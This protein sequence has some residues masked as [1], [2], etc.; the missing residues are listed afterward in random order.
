MYPRWAE[1][2]NFGF[3]EP[4]FIF[5][6]PLSWMLGA[7]LSLIV[8]W[9]I[10]PAV[11]T[12][13]SQTISGISSYALLRRFLPSQGALVGAFIY[14]VNPYALL[15]IYE[16]GAYG[17]VLACALLPFLL[18]ACLDLCGLAECRHRS[19]PQTIVLFALAFS[20]VWLSNVP[21]G[22][23]T[24]YSVGLV[25]AWAAARR[26]SIQPLW[27]GA[28]GLILGFGLNA[29]HLLPV[30]YEQHWASVQQL[31]P[32]WTHSNNFLAQ[33]FLYAQIPSPRG[34]PFA[35]I[36]SNVAVL[37]VGIT[38][39]AS[40]IAHPRTY[41]PQSNSPAENVWVV[42]LLLLILAI[43]LMMPASAIFWRHLPK[44]AV[45][46]FPWRWMGILAVP[47]AFSLAAAI[48]PRRGR[49]VW[50]AMVVAISATVG[51]L[52]ARRGSWGGDGTVTLQK[53]I[54]SGHGFIGAAE[55]YPAGEGS[56]Y[57]TYTYVDKAAPTVQILSVRG[58]EKAASQT[59]IEVMKWTAEEKE[60]RI[61]ASE[62]VSVALRLLNY[63]SWQ[64]KVNGNV[65]KRQQPKGVDKIIVLAP[66][67]E[68]EISARFMR[69]PDR[70]CGN[71]LSLA[72]IFVSVILLWKAR[73]A[74]WHRR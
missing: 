58:L 28:C 19:L 42:L 22:V 16:R 61:R 11:F 10:V 48:A 30:V 57:S 37:L 15:N 35:W 3:G 17:E 14:A 72:S 64:V 31:L 46:Q 51:N 66:A 38:L 68:S 36:A 1:W 29:F 49:W 9:K 24:S 5:Y 41:G 8:P 32:A 20:A 60:V 43:F 2:A 12:V 59:E 13:C 56:Y 23:M 50:L 71:T 65:A 53:A 73:P 44:L 45:M 26:K 18:V 40:L 52:L 27:R 25:F 62:E 33:N 4:R 63:P 54:A 74:H 55:Y 47:Y 34:V 6:P 69:T 39:I 7:A 67:G 70:I 21:A